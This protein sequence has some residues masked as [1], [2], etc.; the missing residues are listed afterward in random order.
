MKVLI[1]KDA[2]A[3]YMRSCY[4]N[5]NPRAYG[6]HRPEYYEKLKLIE[7]KECE[8][9]TDYLFADQFNIVEENLRVMVNVVDKVIDD[10]RIDK[11]KNGYTEKMIDNLDNI[12]DEQKPFI[13]QYKSH[14]NKIVRETGAFVYELYIFDA[15]AVAKYNRYL[16]ESI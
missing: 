5:A 13:T 1:S 8:V 11:Y 15:K 6:L 9:E 16:L 3:I 4:K 7:G 12:P 2:S 14:P 10:V